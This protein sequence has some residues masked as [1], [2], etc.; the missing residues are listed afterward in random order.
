M[1]D[2]RRFDAITTSDSD[3]EERSEWETDDGEGQ[4]DDGPALTSQP[5]APP[6]RR[7]AQVPQRAAFVELAPGHDIRQLQP[8][9]LTHPKDFRAAPDPKRGYAWG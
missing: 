4:A 2:Y 7:A 3:E 9:F 8:I 6:A 5:P 1:V